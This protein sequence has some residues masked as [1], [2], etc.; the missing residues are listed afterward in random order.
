MKNEIVLI[1]AEEPLMRLGLRHFLLQEM[2]LKLCVE[3]GNFT[4]ALK[5]QAEHEPALVILFFC[6]QAQEETV[7]LVRELR[8]RRRQQA[9]LVVARTL[10]REH[11]Q[12][13]IASGALGYV[14]GADGLAELRL[15]CLCVLRGDLH[16]TQE[17]ARALQRVPQQGATRKVPLEV[18][19]LREREVLALMGR[20][21]KGV[22]LAA[23]LGISV[24]TVETH[25]KHLRE[26][27]ELKNITELWLLAGGEMRD[28]V[29]R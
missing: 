16:V 2:G 15:A 4:Q 26:K 27:L 5:Q 6:E 9:V 25:Q 24:K 19:T 14:R 23:E 12:E 22:D 13:C 8:R 18:L 20:G 11:V 3:A 1:V 10:A 17:A 28:A 29:G 7:R 21:V